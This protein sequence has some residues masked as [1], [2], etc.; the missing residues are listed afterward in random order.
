[1]WN[2][3][4][5]RLLALS[6]L[7]LAAGCD[8]QKPLPLKTAPPPIHQEISPAPELP[9]TPPLRERHFS[10]SFVRWEYKVAK[11]Q[12]EGEEELTKFLNDFAAQGWEFVGQLE[13]K[14]KYVVLRRTKITR[15]LPPRD[16]PR[17]P[18][19]GNGSTE[20]EDPRIRKTPGPPPSGK[21]DA[22][23]PPPKFEPTPKS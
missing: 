13:N 22:S 23:V 20:K 19:P 16:L 9:A 17:R 1:M 15:D 4:I 12:K 11:I 6:V 10:E 18:L 7:L 21:P 3:T 2:R 14:A 8:T 5:P